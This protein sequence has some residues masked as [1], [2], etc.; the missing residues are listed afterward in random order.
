MR[1]R[2]GAV[3]LSGVVLSISA[4]ARAEIFRGLDV[5]K[6]PFVVSGGQTVE[7]A[8][9]D[10]GPIPA[11]SNGVVVETAGPIMGPSKA[12][13][14]K[15]DLIWAFSIRV[16]KDVKYDSVAIDEVSDKTASH[17]ITAENIASKPYRTPDG[18]SLNFL[19]LRSGAVPVG[20]ESTSWVYKVGPSL[21]VYRIV[22]KEETG[23]TVT[24]FQP[25]FFREPEKDQ[26]RKMASTTEV[27]SSGK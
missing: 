5:K 26:I 11:Q 9:T 7:L 6:I 18:Q 12:I 10:Q 20:P 17:I 13:P 25:A 4:P 24:L 23:N 15:L 19:I 27:M 8:V 14:G 3:L 1:K 16:P 2:V 22:L 21:F